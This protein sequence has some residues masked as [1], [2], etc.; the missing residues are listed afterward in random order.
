[1]NRVRL[2]VLASL[3]LAAGACAAEG[4][5]QATGNTFFTGSAVA[6]VLGVAIAA[7]GCAVGMGICIAQA[8]QGIARQPE[9]TPKLQLNMMIGLAFIET[10]ILYTLFI[11]IIL[12]FA[13]PLI[14][15][16]VPH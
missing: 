15:Y 11:A 6:A 16:V 4:A 14:K 3:A 13:N 1:M 10:L 12:L 9:V 7:V 5:A 8:L 2:S